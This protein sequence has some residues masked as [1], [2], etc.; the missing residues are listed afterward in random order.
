M[1]TG[2]WDFSLLIYLFVLSVCTT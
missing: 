1:I 2:D